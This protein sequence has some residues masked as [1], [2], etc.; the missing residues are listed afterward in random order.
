MTIHF[1]SCVLLDDDFTFDIDRIAAIVRE[2]F[3]QIGQIDALPGVSATAGLLTI[4]EGL[5]VVEHVPEPMA[6]AELW[7]SFKPLRGWDPVPAV[8]RHRSHLIVSCGGDN[9]PGV[10][11]A[12][13]FAAAAT[14]VAG[15]LA[16]ATPASAAFWAHGAVLLR[17]AEMVRAADILLQGRAPRDAWLSYEPIVP[18]GFARDQALG[19]VTHGLRPF[20]GREIELAPA[21]RTAR[22]CYL[23]LVVAIDHLLGR[24]ITP[25]DGDEISGLDGHFAC[26]LRL[27]RQWWRKGVPAIVLV[28][29]ESLVD[30]DTLALPV[31]RRKAAARP[32]T[33]GL[34]D[35]PGLRPAAMGS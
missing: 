30:P 22:E 28:E 15:A 3:P 13:T 32:R 35:R 25:R 17:P 20:L 34:F 9:L 1:T 2:R 4:D 16:H 11:G 14:F 29:E 10:E 5:V 27:R 24:C 19:L 18:R 7:P 6:P 23:R 33:R 31:P 26:T 8:T 21:A 12:K